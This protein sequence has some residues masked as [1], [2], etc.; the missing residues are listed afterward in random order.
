MIDVE[1]VSE[2]QRVLTF[3]LLCMYSYPNL[4]PASSCDKQSYMP[5]SSLAL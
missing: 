5:A 1:V 2:I 4:Q 3:A